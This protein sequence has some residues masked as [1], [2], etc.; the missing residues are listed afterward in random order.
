MQGGETG[1]GET[2][3]ALELELGSEEGTAPG[4]GAATVGS[5]V[6][7]VRPGVHVGRV[8]GSRPGP[9]SLGPG[10]SAVG[11][12]PRA[13]ELGGTGAALV[14]DIIVVLAGRLV[15]KAESRSARPSRVTD[16]R[17][18]EAGGRPRVGVAAGAAKVAVGSCTGG[19]VS[20]PPAPL[21]TPAPALFGVADDAK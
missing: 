9:A 15:T 2:S 13:A 12:G 14:G 3:P 1:V 4:S 18:E 16:G 7:P 5:E 20:A 8:D 11:L 21:R 6:G 19:N 10:S 17:R